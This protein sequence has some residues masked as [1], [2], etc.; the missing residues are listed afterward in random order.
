MTH[1]VSFVSKANPRKSFYPPS[2]HKPSPSLQSG[3]SSRNA[4]KLKPPGEKKGHNPLSQPICNYCKQS[5]HIVSD[6]AVLK[7]KREKQEGFKPTGLTSLKSTTQSCV[8]DQNPA[9]AKV[10]ETDFV[11]DIYEPFLSD[12]FVSLNSDFVQ[13]APIT[14]LR[15]TGAS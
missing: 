8:K 7:R 11:T 10:P 1:N 14:I 6:C 2:G 4:L 13:S 3:N 15:D 9:Q 12:G 5:G